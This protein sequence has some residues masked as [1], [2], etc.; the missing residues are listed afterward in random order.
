MF[1][2]SYGNECQLRRN[3]KIGDVF[4]SGSISIALSMAHFLNLYVMFFFFD[5]ILRIDCGR[6]VSKGWESK[7]PLPRITRRIYSILVDFSE[8]KKK[9]TYLQYVCENVYMDDMEVQ[10]YIYFLR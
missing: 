1:G 5:V 3:Y 8:E 2:G 10:E 7:Q 6:T 4:Q 9:G